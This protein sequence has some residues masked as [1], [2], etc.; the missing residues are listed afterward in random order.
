MLRSLNLGGNLIGPEGVVLLAEGLRHNASLVCLNL[1]SNRAGDAGAVAVAQML[2]DNVSLR[3]LYLGCNGIEEAGALALAHS[4]RA[5]T[6][7]EKVDVQGARVGAA[8]VHAIA[9]A[10]RRNSSLRQLVLDVEPALA[11]H[12]ATDAREAIATALRANTSL[13][14]LVVGE[15]RLVDEATLGG[16]RATLRVNRAIVEMRS[17]AAPHG[18]APHA[19]VADAA[20]A[21]RRRV[22]PVPLEHDGKVLGDGPAALAP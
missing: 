11:P 20:Q 12:E 1:R 14:E 5:N 15:S 22:P 21:K 17:A 7:L 19:E 9:E 6:A 4:W 16:V 10:L 2:C 18:V 8:A 13:T 3:E